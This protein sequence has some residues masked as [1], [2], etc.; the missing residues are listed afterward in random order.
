MPRAQADEV[1]A[2]RTQL[3]ALHAALAAKDTESE[4]KDRCLA[5]KDALIAVMHQVS[6]CY[7]SHV[8]GGNHA[9]QLCMLMAEVMAVMPCIKLLRR[10]ISCNFMSCY[11]MLSQSLSSQSSHQAC[12]SYL[13]IAEIRIK[14]AD[15]GKQ[16]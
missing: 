14:C 9:S 5:S 11:V 10:V 16:S 1:A 3:E 8:S 2:L 6:P 12:Q 7:V 13:L 15:A 4:A